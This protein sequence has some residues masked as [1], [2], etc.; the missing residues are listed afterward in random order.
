MQTVGTFA[1]T[2]EAEIARQRLADAGIQ[3]FITDEHSQTLGYQPVLGGIRLQ[4]ADADLPRARALLD[5]PNPL[6]LP[7]DFEPEGAPPQATALAPGVLG[8]IVRAFIRGGLIALTAYV[9][10]ALATTFFGR[11]LLVGPRAVFG[12]FLAGGII[13]LSL[14]VIS[15]PRRPRG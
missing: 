15:G 8:Q 9:I 6:A 7:E 1:N 11:P 4:V 3:A 14:R 13:G 2:A 12:L 10:V 5:A